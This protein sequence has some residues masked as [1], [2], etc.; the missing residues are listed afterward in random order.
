MKEKRLLEL[1][2]INDLRRRV[3][4]TY[5]DWDKWTLMQ[6]QLLLLRSS[7][8]ELTDKAGYDPSWELANMFNVPQPLIRQAV[9]GSPSLR[10]ALADYD[11]DNA[12][13]YGKTLKGKKMKRRTSQKDLLELISYEAIIGAI[14]GI[15]NGARPRLTEPEKPYL[16]RWYEEL[17][18]TFKRTTTDEEDDIGYDNWG[19]PYSLAEARRERRLNPYVDDD[20]GLPTGN[21]ATASSD[22]EPPKVKLVDVRDENGESII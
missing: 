5:P 20:S 8:G 11:R 19:N 12:Y 21:W 17:D 14:V 9:D 7:H 6:R 18:K 16:R 1:N 4:S 10:K 15:Q 3:K 13:G 2:T 22:D